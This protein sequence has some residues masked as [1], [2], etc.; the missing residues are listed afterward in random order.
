MD[1]SYTAEQ[2]AFRTEIRSWLEARKAEG[3][4][5]GNLHDHLDK[6]VERGQAWQSRL[7]EARWCGV[8]WPA[9]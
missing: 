4:I 5:P 8:H 2:E 6:V 1:F 7:A 9:V 3:A